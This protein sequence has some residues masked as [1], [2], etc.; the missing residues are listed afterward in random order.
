MP[1]SETTE[2]LSWREQLDVDKRLEYALVN[3]IDEYRRRRHRG[4]QARQRT[5]RPLDVIEGPLMAGMNVVGDLFGDRQD[6][7][8]AGCEI[9]AR[10][11]ERRSA[12][13][14]RS[15]RNEKGRRG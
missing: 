12:I 14:C 8:A 7:P 4:S 11:E 5:P 15:S 1:Q 3:G 2:S 13:S 9:G 10:D 6:V